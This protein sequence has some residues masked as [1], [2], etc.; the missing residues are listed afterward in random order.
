MDKSVI[1]RHEA[2]EAWP[3]LPTAGRLNEVNLSS[4]NEL[5]IPG[6][7]VKLI[8]LLRIACNDGNH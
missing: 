1:S 3:S 4:G 2:T 7:S 5:H 6:V 8:R